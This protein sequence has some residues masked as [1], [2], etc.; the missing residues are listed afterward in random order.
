M[1]KEL[2]NNSIDIQGFVQTIREF[3]W[4]A[5]V[6]LRIPN[7]NVQI[8]LTKDLLPSDFK[9]ESFVKVTGIV[10]ST[11]IK[12]LS[13]N[14][15]DFEVCA[16]QIEI[17]SEPSIV[18]PFDTTKKELNLNSDLRFDLRP[19]SLRHPKQKAIFKIQ[20]VI[21]NEFSNFLTKAD[22]T[23]ICS[24][25]I[26]ETGV[27]GGSN[28]FEVPYFGKTA[29]LAQSPQ[30][31]KQM[32]VGVF[33]KV[34]ET[35]SVFRAEKHNTS[36]HLN[37]YVSLDLEMVLENGFEDLIKIEI[38]FITHLLSVLENDYRYELDLLGVTLPEISF[39]SITFEEAHNI[40]FEKFEKDF[41]QENDLCPE[42]E[43][44]ICEHFEK[45]FGISFVFVTHYPTSKRP[46]YAKED[47]TNPDV[48]LSFDLLFR[49]L[50]ITTGGQRLHKYEEYVDK[51]TKLGMNIEPLESYLQTFKYC[52]P[53]HGGFAIG[54]ERLVAQICGISNVKDC[55]L[56]PRDCDRLNP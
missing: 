38:N 4:G 29:Y 47:S 25:K 52:M 32:S 36:R 13:V 5:F 51:M 31:Y 33:G 15:K 34:F 2:E 12:D 27:E 7:Y 49:G 28:V 42:E 10:K 41:R 3:S 11:K 18:L 35:G 45:E 56:F 40:V 20:S 9:I 1:F 55:S 6:I 19:L 22:F 50:E 17:I 54:L 48:T 23:R 30:L 37:E 26:V 16:T 21:Y 39:G 44:L 53:P 46:F 14:P 43:K 8:V 24:P